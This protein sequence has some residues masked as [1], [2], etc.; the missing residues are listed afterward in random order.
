VIG[1]SDEIGA[2]PKDRPIPAGQV[3]A[4]VLHGLGIP[5]DEDLPGPGGRPIRIVDHG[6][7]PITELF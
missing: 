1:A 7:E 2:Y 6:V 4:T 5:L 3:A